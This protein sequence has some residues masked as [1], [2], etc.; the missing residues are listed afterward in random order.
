MGRSPKHARPCP[1]PLAIQI[2][3]PTF[4]T[5]YDCNKCRSLSTVSPVIMNQSRP[6]SYHRY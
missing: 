3:N 2:P 4:C 6:E 5:M 1:W